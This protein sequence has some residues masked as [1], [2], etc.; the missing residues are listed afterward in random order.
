MVFTIN[1][2]K[3]WNKFFFQYLSWSKLR[4]L[5][6]ITRT[7]T[8]DSLLFLIKQ[9]VPTETGTKSFIHAPSQP[10]FQNGVGSGPNIHKQIQIFHLVLDSFLLGSQ[11]IQAQRFLRSVGTKLLTWDMRQM[12]KCRYDMCKLEKKEEVW[13]L[14]Q[15]RM[16]SCQCH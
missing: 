16:C 11:T 6:P 8:I 2:S 10:W 5:E 4:G 3:L 14:I 1:I 7:I 13:F 15:F 9:E 12:R